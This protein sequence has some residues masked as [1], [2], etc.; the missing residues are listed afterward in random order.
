MSEAKVKKLT[1]PFLIWL[2]SITA[3]GTP[4]LDCYGSHVLHSMTQHSDWYHP[5]LI[6]SVDEYEAMQKELAKAQKKAERAE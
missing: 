2:H 4:S 3:D 1:Q 6:I 5:A